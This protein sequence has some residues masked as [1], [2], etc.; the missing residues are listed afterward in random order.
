[1]N[2]SAAIRFV[3]NQLCLTTCLEIFMLFMIESIE[4]ISL[5]CYLS[6]PCHQFESTIYIL[7]NFG[8]N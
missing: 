4:Y 5:S 3:C 6:Q 1:M 2:L 8:A 7:L